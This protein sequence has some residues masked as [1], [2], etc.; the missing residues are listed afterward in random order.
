MLLR[1]VLQAT[2]LYVSLCLLFVTAL[3]IICVFCSLCFFAAVNVYTGLLGQ[4]RK[5]D[6]LR[7]YLFD[8]KG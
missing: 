3:C 2:D 5:E 1:C 8:T 6:K 4:Q 7:T